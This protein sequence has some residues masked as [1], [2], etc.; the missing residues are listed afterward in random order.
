MGRII[1]TYVDD[2]IY[3]SRPFLLKDLLILDMLTFLTTTSMLPHIAS[4]FELRGQNPPPIYSDFFYVT[5]GLMIHATVYVG[6]IIL[7]CIVRVPDVAPFMVTFLPSLLAM[8]W[9]AFFIFFAGSLQVQWQTLRV[10]RTQ[11]R[12]G[13]QAMW[14]HL[15]W[16]AR[17]GS[18]M[19]VMDRGEVVEGVQELREPGIVRM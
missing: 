12:N 9:A 10:R 17:H 18:W 6:T 4:L 2:L 5:L 3:A 1:S 19:E 15:E 13:R 16:W 11:V 14:A 8:L 7:Q